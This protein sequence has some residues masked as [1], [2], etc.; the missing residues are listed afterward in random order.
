MIYAD[1]EFYVNEYYGD[2]LTEDNFSKFASRA[3]DYIDRVTMGRANA[4]IDAV[5]KACCAAAEQYCRINSAKE[6]ATAGELASE[7]VGSYSVTYRSSV[8]LS[9]ALEKELRGIVEGYLAN[10]GLL[11]RGIPCIRPM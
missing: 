10:T 7:T 9:A 6:S 5:K 1:Y 8:E 4:E 2:I 11:Y 3:S